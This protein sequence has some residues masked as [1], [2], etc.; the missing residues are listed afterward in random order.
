MVLDKHGADVLRLWA[1]SSDYFEDLNIGKKTLEQKAEVYRKL[2]NTFRFLVSNLGDFKPEDR[3]DYEKLSKLDKCV[4]HRLAELDEE[5]RNAYNTYQFNRIYTE[6]VNFCNSELSS[7]Y[8]DI[9]K[10][11]LYCDSDN[12]VRRLGTLTVFE[13]V[14]KCLVT[15]LAPFIPFAAEEVW[16]TLYPNSDSVHLQFFHEVDDNWFDEKLTNEWK[17]VRM[18]R[19]KVDAA[20]EVLRTQKEIKS[21]MEARVTVYMNNEYKQ[22]VDEFDMA[23]FCIVSDF[24]AAYGSELD[25]VAVKAST[26]KCERCWNLKN[27]VGT[28]DNH[29]TLCGRCVDV[30]ETQ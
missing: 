27:D 11:S 14:F 6:L 7:L 4:L 21:N 8:F 24:D 15:W 23:E 12:S 13:H 17:M 26:Q 25:V 19:N 1:V 16:Q 5:V 22:V 18:V 10:D 29:P 28:Y 2:R 9:R 30:V 20:L 3:Q